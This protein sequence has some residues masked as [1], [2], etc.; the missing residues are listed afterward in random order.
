MGV[1][2]TQG[3]E[4]RL[5]VWSAGYLRGSDT[6]MTRRPR[7][8]FQAQKGHVCQAGCKRFRLQNASR[9]S[10]PDCELAM[11]TLDRGSRAVP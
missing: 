5:A 4:P 8:T 2:K 7:R 3:D 1:E 6:W 9:V 11:V 10:H